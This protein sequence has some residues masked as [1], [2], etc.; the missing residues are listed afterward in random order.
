MVNRIE[1]D[2]LGELTRIN[3]GGQGIVYDAPS[4]ATNF[5]GAMVY[6]EYTHQSLQTIDV[7]VL[8]AMPAFLES[9]S[10]S[11]GERL[12]S[13]AAWPC[14]TVQAHGALTG[15]V[16]PKL[17][18]DFFISLNT[19]KGPGPSLAEMQ[20]LLNPPEFLAK[21][22]IA[23]TDEQR[24]RLLRETASALVFLHA[25]G[26][27]VGDLS[28]K[29]LLF[30]L[31][32]PAVHFID[33]DA[34]RVNGRSALP[35]ADTPAWWT[36]DGEEKATPQSDTYKLGLLAL[37]LF[38]GEQH[39][40]DPT[41]LPDTTPRLL[42][43]LIT[44]TLTR[45]APKR[46]APLAWT[47]ILGRV[48]EDLQH[49]QDTTPHTIAAAQ[50]APK[51][52]AAAALTPPPVISGNSG[53]PSPLAT[54]PKKPATSGVPIG[55]V[56]AVAAIALLIAL[57][58][59]AVASRQGNNDT[60]SAART[61]TAST[62]YVTPTPT[63]VPTTTTPWYTP[64][65]TTTTTTSPTPTSDEQPYWDGPWIRNY[66]EDP[67]DCDNGLNYWVVQ[68]GA[69]STMHALKLGCL[70]TNWKN[71]I[72]KRCQSYKF[73]PGKCAVWDHDR[74]LSVY[75]KH[76]DLLVIAISQHCLDRAGLDDFHEG[77]LNT[78]CVLTPPGM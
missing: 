21:L 47:H 54:V 49:H 41:S 68:P 56:V 62:V 33:C 61:V 74:I 73:G 16:M 43:Q 8:D 26:I 19:A 14:A 59:K 75:K 25:N 27:C 7:D 58:V 3:R 22:G 30:R 9:L 32:P 46:P 70:P 24:C 60:S 65:T 71:A 55:A 48:V 66:W 18:P 11:E 2:K 53:G 51:P 42:R 39:L 4:V 29:N 20:H 52:T 57:G 37:R 50:S 38:A 40:K 23:I 36:P 34:M 17:S 77:P 76:G 13:T 67:V 1:R 63:T 72:T 10:A 69:D 35:Q 6:K 5:T 15:F 44:E 31:D 28:P 64:T 12:I 78:D 45:P